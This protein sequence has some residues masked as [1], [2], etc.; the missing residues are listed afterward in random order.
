L[1]KKLALFQRL[2]EAALQKF[3]A[4][5]ELKLKQLFAMLNVKTPLTGAGIS[6]R[7]GLPPS[8]SVCI[9]ADLAWLHIIT[10]VQQSYLLKTAKSSR[11]MG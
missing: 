9:L 4:D 6:K 10:Q 2:I 7:E 5:L 11:Y 3:R 8:N 1:H